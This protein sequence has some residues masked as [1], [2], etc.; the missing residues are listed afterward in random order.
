M[1]AMDG[2][3]GLVIASYVAPAIALDKGKYE[4]QR[5]DRAALARRVYQLAAGR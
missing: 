5:R 1:K 2:P 3:E 4:A